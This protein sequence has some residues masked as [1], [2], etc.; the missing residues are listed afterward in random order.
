MGGSDLYP[1]RNANQ[2]KTQRHKSTLV[3]LQHA[4]HH[5]VEQLGV[6]LPSKNASTYE[7]LTNLA[8]EVL[9]QITGIKRVAHA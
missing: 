3:W 9:V 6:I 2:F 4:N 8:G 1:S 5:N 7:S